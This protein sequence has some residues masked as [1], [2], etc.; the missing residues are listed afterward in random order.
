MK[1]HNVRGADKIRNGRMKKSWEEEQLFVQGA[2][3]FTRPPKVCKMFVHIRV[4]T[5]Q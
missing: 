3:S 1:K 2:L 5:R 4:Y